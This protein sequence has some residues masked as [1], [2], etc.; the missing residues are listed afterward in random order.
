ML[1]GLKTVGDLLQRFVLS[2]DW[3]K[4]KICAANKSSTKQI[5][6]NCRSA[7]VQIVKGPIRLKTGR[8][9]ERQIGGLP[10]F[11]KWAAC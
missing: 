2:P 8:F 10:T 5:Q 3:S 11:G 1:V 6:K 7:S 4:S 9:A